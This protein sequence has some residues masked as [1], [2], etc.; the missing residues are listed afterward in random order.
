MRH[1]HSDARK[2]VLIA[3]GK[4]HRGSWCRG[5]TKTACMR[6]FIEAFNDG[7]VV[8]DP[9]VRDACPRVSFGT[10]YRWVCDERPEPTAL[11]KEHF[12]D[13][14][15]FDSEPLRTAVVALSARF[16]GV[17]TTLLHTHL[18]TALPGCSIPS[19]RSLC[20]Y[21]KRKR[22]EDPKGVGVSVEPKARLPRAKKGA[23]P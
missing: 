11:Q 22:E 21:L 19:V 1:L 23:K 20:R 18:V 13:A 15:A 9:R 10:L 4:W 6:G 7:L 12:R 5:Q 3:W 8:C 2:A 17:S 14:S 16:P